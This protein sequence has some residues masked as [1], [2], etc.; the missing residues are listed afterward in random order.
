MPTEPM[1]IATLVGALVQA[2]PLAVVEL[3][4]DQKGD[5]FQRWM[6]KDGT[7][8]A[9]AI[10]WDLASNERP[11][12]CSV[13]ANEFNPPWF[14]VQYLAGAPPETLLFEWSLPWSCMH[15][16]QSVWKR[17]VNAPKTDGE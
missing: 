6:W 2:A 5:F 14:Y 4:I 16:W 3:W 7:M 9:R 17:P 1:H 12:A 13:W 11:G 10:A 8:S 15:S